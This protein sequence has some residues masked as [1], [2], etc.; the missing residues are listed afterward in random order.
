[1]PCLISLGFPHQPLSSS[2]PL[3]ST[4]SCALLP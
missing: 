4:S 1:V 2:S 3:L